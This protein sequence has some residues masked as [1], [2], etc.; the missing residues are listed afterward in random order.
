MRELER[1]N[2]SKAPARDLVEH[3]EV[4]VGRVGGIVV[5]RDVLAEVS[6]RGVDAIGVQAR[7]DLE[8]VLEHRHC[9]C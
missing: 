3:P 4:R 8:G 2:R 5:G 6:H 1:G 9:R 7:H